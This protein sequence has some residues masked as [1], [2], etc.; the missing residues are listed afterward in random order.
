M[1]QNPVITVRNVRTLDDLV[2]LEHNL[3]KGAADT[4]EIRSAVEARYADFGRAMVASKTGLDLEGLSPAESRILN[5]VGRYVALQKREGKSAPRTFQII[6]NR[7]LIDA[8]EV[9]VGKSKVTQGFDVL[10]DADMR[11]LSFEQI[12]VDYPDEFSARALWYANRALGYPNSLTKPPADLGTVT[13]QRTEKLIDWLSTRAQR[14]G[15]LLNGYTNA[16]LGAHLGFDDLTRHGR[17][18]GNMQ[19]RIDFG[20]Y[21][22]GAPPL[23][24]CAVEHFSRGWAAEG[25]RWAFPVEMMRQSAQSF[26]WTD[27]VFDSVR[28]NTRALPGQA[29]IPWRRELLEHEV[30]VRTWAESMAPYAVTPNEMLEAISSEALVL[31]ETEKKLLARTPEVRERISKSIER[32]SIGQKLKRANNFKCQLCDTLGLNPIGFVKANGEPYVEA[33]HAT[34]V[35]ELEIGSLAASNIM[36]LCANHHREMHYGQVELER[37]EREFIIRL[38]GQTLRIERFAV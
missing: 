9:T 2:S 35:S 4:P 3:Q 22:A 37:D 18:L 13:Q 16:E 17:H 33:H 36:I 26:V 6:A 19:S 20:C 30:L 34:P 28:V 12:I 1:A 23:G 8:A 24:L 5:A 7:G 15:G 38:E 27:E 32:G 25:R 21:R 11:E 29:A 10:D 31:V 14:N